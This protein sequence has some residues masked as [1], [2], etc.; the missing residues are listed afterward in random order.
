MAEKPEAPGRSVG[1]RP[2]AARNGRAANRVI[3]P[4]LDSPL[5]PLLSFRL[6]LLRYTGRRS[7][8]EYTIPVAYSRWGDGEVIATSRRPV[9]AVNLRGG[10]PVQLRIRGRWYQATPTIVTEPDA[11]AEQLGDFVRAVGPR[12]A[13]MLRIGLPRLRQPTPQELRAV[14]SKHLLARFRLVDGPSAL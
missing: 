6:M 11:V 5:H 14:A 3:R 9:W 12:A 10:Q 1:A 4:L 8:R 2:A 7:G 13:G